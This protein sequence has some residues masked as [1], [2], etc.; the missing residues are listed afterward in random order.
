MP[1][2]AAALMLL[3]FGPAGSACARDR[4]GHPV[5]ALPPRRAGDPID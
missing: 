1:R 2:L 3:L 4:L 5:T